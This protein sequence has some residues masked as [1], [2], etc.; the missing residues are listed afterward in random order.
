[1]T[2]ELEVRDH[3]RRSEE[4]HLART[5]KE[6]QKILEAGVHSEVKKWIDQMFSREISYFQHRVLEHSLL[7]IKTVRNFA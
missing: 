5:R 7:D 6:Q 4:H 1:M 2:D 3:T